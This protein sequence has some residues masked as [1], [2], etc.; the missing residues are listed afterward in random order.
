M[1]APTASTLRAAALPRP[2]YV[3]AATVMGVI[4]LALSLSPFADAFLA[5]V[6]L[7]YAGTS[8][9]YILMPFVRRGDIPLVAAWVVLLSELAPCVTGQLISPVKVTADALGVAMA[10]A[11]IFIARLRQ[12]LQGDTRPAGRRAS[13]RG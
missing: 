7:F 4:V 1:F 13:E 10:T 2:L 12:V 11:P 3:G 8:G 9:A 6:L 5:R